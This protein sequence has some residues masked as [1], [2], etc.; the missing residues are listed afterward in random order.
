MKNVLPIKS[1]YVPRWGLWES[2][3]ELIQNSK[4]EEQE[5]AHK[6]SVHYHKGWLHIENEG[7]DLRVNAL[8]IGHSTKAG[9][10][11][12]RGEH[13]E[14]LDLAFLAG[15]RAGHRIEVTTKTEKWIPALEQR[16]EYGW[17]RCLVINV[18]KLVK[19]RSGVCVS[20]CMDEKEWEAIKP[21]FLFLAPSSA[22]IETESGDLLLDE[23]RCGEI[24]VKDIYVMNAHKTFGYGFNLK[25]VRLDRDRQMIG[26]FDLQWEMSRVIMLALDRDPKHFAGQVMDLFDKE[27]EE[28][29]YIGSQITPGSEAGRALAAEFRTRHGDNAVPVRSMAESQILESFGARGV[30]VSNAAAKA[31]EYEM[32]DFHK[33]KLRLRV[34][35]IARYGWHDLTAK[36]QANLER[37]QAAIRSITEG[38]MDTLAALQVVDF[39]ETSGVLG[40]CNLITG[41]MQVARKRCGNF[42]DLLED[43]VHELAHALSQAGDLTVSHT[44]TLEKLWRSLYEKAVQP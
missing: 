32:G 30:L 29:E 15:I 6:M 3:R 1:T 41:E 33:A 31:L 9:K 37:A 40:S 26:G 43:L 42:F 10:R 4:D 14:G 20:V 25:N 18:R 35:P 21:K 17:E 28:V 8:L 7:A 22:S 38:K 19:E 13:G 44:V 12:L 24:F 11:E 16:E 2:L 36:E 39:H 23:S 5:N 34:Q 27:S